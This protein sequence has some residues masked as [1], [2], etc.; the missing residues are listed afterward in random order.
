L[1][2][3]FLR[4]FLPPL[5]F[6]VN[7][8]FWPHLMNDYRNIL[9]EKK[10]DVLTGLGSKIDRSPRIGPV[11]ED[12]QAQLANEESVSL[13]LNNLD[14]NRLRLID[15]ALDRIE[16][17]HY[18]V[19]LSCEEPIPDRRLNAIPWANYCVVCQEAVTEAAA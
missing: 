7:P 10:K 13:R 11:N 9:L 12:D 2:K 14:Y 15:A 1:I 19:C 4:V 3:I 6:F 16:T 18:G 8:A 5:H 17:G